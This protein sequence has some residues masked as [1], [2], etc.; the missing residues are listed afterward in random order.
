[1]EKQIKKGLNNSE[2]LI[3]RQ[4]YGSNKMTKK[5]GKGFFRLFV[6]NMGDPVIRVLIITLAVNVIL[7]IRNID[8]FETGGIITAI[9]LATTISTFSVTF[10]DQV[11]V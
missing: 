7:T 5:K 6:E 3:S 8:W 9:L 1:M 4:R 2:V 10:T 11:R